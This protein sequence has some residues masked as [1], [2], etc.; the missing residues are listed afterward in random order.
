MTAQQSSQLVI[1]LKF[2][3]LHFLSSIINAEMVPEGEPL[4]TDMKYKGYT[5]DA[6]AVA[7]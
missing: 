7:R 6:M 3:P 2:A 4:L 5:E 1:S